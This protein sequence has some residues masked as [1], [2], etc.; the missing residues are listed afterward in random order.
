MLEL[1]SAGN[2]AASAGQG[3]TDSNP[4]ARLEAFCDGV[5]SVALT[6]LIIDIAIPST[7]VINSNADFWRALE[8]I[9]P[10]FGAFLLS[11]V[12]V[13]INWANHHATLK[14]VDKS[15]FPFMYANGFFL[16]TV[17]FIP[18]PTSLLGKYITTDYASPAVVLY[19]GICA[20]QG[21]GWFLLTLTA[22]RPDRLLTKNAYA[23][24]KMRENHQYSYYAIGLYAACTLLAFWF[25]EPIAIVITVSW[26]GWLVR[27]IFIQADQ[28]S[29]SYGEG[30]P[31][32]VHP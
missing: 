26:I 7:A 20:L 11:F 12:M 18:F 22:L 19:S 23:T 14:L 17:V 24:L 3:A 13:F 25:P 5:F 31:E 28:E 1:E 2:G 27:G 30:E 16:L 32:R 9:A 21:V 15:S 29:S 6:L 10:S 8:D 4:N